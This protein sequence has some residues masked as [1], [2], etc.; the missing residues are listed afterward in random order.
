MG[1]LD[2]TTHAQYY[3]GNDLGNYQFVS[4]NDIINQFMVVYVGE[5]KIIPNAKRTDVA[6]H[7]QRALAELS[8]DTLKS[9]KTQ[10]IDVPATL[11]M[12]LPHDYVN[13]TRIMWADSAGIKHPLYPTRDTQNPFQIAQHDDGDYVFE[14]AD[15]E[16]VNGDFSDGGNLIDTWGRHSHNKAKANE[17]EGVVEFKHATKNY[18]NDG[19]TERWGFASVLYQELD[20]SD[21]INLILNA[22]GLAQDIAGTNADG[23]AI[24]H[25]G[26][27]RVGLTTYDPTLS[28]VVINPNNNTD[29]YTNIDIFDP[30][31]N[32]VSSSESY[33]YVEWLSGDGSSLSTKTISNID[34]SSIDKVW[35]IAISFHNFTGSEIVAALQQTQK[36]D[37]IVVE[38]TSPNTS[39]KSPVGNE[40]ESS[41]W[42]NYKS[43]TPSENNNDDYEDDTYWPMDGKRY[44]LDP[45]HAQVNG[46]FYIDQ[47]LGKIHFSSNIS[48]KTVILDYI[49]DSLG[50][51]DEMQVH[52]FAE[53]AIY[54]FISYGIISS[55]SNTPEYI[56]QRFKKEKFAETRKAKLRLSNL[57]L[58][59]LTQ[60]LRGKSKWI[61]H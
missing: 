4:L 11:T 25:D 18:A 1:L 10:Q 31:I 12:M 52:K 7:A 37:N 27:L 24:S 36:L 22:D 43:T 32:G 45:S 20:V 56:V 33:S 51:D 15:N 54:K 5:D 41:T 26:V 23:D 48:G 3:E 44:G 61:K 42:Q 14:V 46:S 29:L 17:N 28:G 57:K 49:S 13:Y 53:E 59:E 19:Q 21:K 40:T 8:F 47:R 16:V 58:E 39:L 34:V 6:F 38:A 30:S 55:R 35:V 50:T 9:I 2:G 60:I